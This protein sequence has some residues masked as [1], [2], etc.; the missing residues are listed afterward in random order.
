MLDFLKVS[1]VKSV[2]LKNEKRQLTWYILV[3][4][5]KFD[6]TS[7][8]IVELIKSESTPVV[9]PTL[10]SVSLARLFSKPELKV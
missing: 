8:L 2:V 1:R 3:F 6:L 9:L 7:S 10:K 4:C 5:V